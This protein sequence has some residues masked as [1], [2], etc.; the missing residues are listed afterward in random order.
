MVRLKALHFRPH[1]HLLL[2][3]IPN[4]TIKSSVHLISAGYAI[5]FQF[6]MVRLKVALMVSEAGYNGRFNY[7]GYD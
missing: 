1:Y 6:Q 3:S 4:G 7:K 2:V 5:L